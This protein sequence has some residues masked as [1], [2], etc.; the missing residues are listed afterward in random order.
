MGDRFP[1]IPAPDSRHPNGAGRGGPNSVAITHHAAIAV[2][3]VRAC[4]LGGIIFITDRQGL[5]EHSN[6][7]YA[8]QEAEFQRPARVIHH[9]LARVADMRFVGRNPN[10]DHTVTVID[11][12]WRATLNSIPSTV[13]G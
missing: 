2:L 7:A 5:E 4:I 9:S 10:D 6:G 11:E 8:T 12:E 1:G 3:D 13:S